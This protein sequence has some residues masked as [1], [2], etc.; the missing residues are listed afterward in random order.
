[1]QRPFP[2]L[3]KIILTTDTIDQL[4]SDLQTAKDDFS[5]QLADL[6]DKAILCEASEGTCTAKYPLLLSTDA[7]NAGSTCT[8]ETE[9][10]INYDKDA[11]SVQ[12]CNG[13]KVVD[14][15]SEIFG[16]E[17]LPGESCAHI[18][19][20]GDA[21]DS[22]KGVYYVQL[23]GATNQVSVGQTVMIKSACDSS[24]TTPPNPK[25]Q[26]QIPPTTTTTTAAAAAA[27]TIPLTLLFIKFFYLF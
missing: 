7:A 9:G 23:N 18:F 11:K 20:E 25:P 19:D 27:A 12:V 8:A 3:L 16:T 2:N 22:K 26:T 21:R 15:Q 13:K 1:M 24:H 10:A 6:A 14:V 4:S 17:T 5:K